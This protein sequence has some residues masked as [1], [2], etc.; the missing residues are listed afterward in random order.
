MNGIRARTSLVVLC[1][2]L[3]VPRFGVALGQEE[4]PVWNDAQKP[5]V[6]NVERYVAAFNRG[7][8]KGLDEFFA[9][10]ARLVTV[11]GEILEGR[12]AI[13]ELFREGFE[14]NPGLSLSSDIRSVRLIG[15]SVAIETGF[16]T[17]KTT[18]DPK[19]DTIAYEIVHVRRDGRWRMFD[20]FETAPADDG[21]R[22]LHAEKLA[23]LDFLA[24]EWIEEAESA[25]IEHSVRWTSNHRFLILNYQSEAADG[26]PIRVAEQRIGWDPRAKTI[27]SW[28]FEEDGGHATS[29]WTTTA[30][31]SVWTIRVDGV[32]ADGRSIASTLK[33]ERVSKDRIRIH[34]Y[35]RSIDGSDQPDAPTR[36]LVR[37]PPAAPPAAGGR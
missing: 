17:T 1:L 7:E 2:A 31:G 35:D 12:Q 23:P 3:A 28:L 19:P 26:K 6:E 33:L 16:I 32:L 8:T 29:T 9:E 15:D 34:G 27:K 25:T 14:S 21:P 36:H 10:D 20:I 11:D 37:K 13:L 5:V 22:E 18:A 30:D 24:G 4:K